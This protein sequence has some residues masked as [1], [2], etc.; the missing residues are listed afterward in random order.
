MADRIEGTEAVVVSADGPGLLRTYALTYAIGAMWL[1]LEVV[2]LGTEPRYAFNGPY[3]AYLTLPPFLTA[4][5]LLLVDR[6]GSWRTLP[7]RTVVLSLIAGVASVISTVVLT[8]ILVLLFREGVGFSL[9][10]SA[11]VS[12]VSLVVVVSPLVIE[13]ITAGRSQRW[14]HVGVLVAGLAVAGVAFAMALTPEGALASSMRSDQGQILMITSSWWLPVYAIAS[15]FTRR[16]G[17]A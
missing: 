12:A 4:L 16:A 9:S 5:C 14:L 1:A 8:P 3:D 2:L 13:L 7:M 17:L 15:A 6:F 11:L 10:A